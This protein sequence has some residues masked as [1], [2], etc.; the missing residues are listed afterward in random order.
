[1]FSKVIFFAILIL[2][3]IA[4]ISDEFNLLRDWELFIR[5]DRSLATQIIIWNLAPIE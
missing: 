4:V 2:L 5:S 1:M 3:N